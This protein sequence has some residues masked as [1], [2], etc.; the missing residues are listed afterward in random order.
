MDNFLTAEWVERYRLHWNEQSELLQGLKGFSALI[1]YGWED[2]S[3]PSAFLLVEDGRAIAAGWGE[4]PGKPVFVMKA[5]A[6]NWRRLRE[7]T[8]SGRAALLTKK[9]KFQGSMITAMKYMGPFEKSI[10]LLSAV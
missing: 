4:A 1:E 6:E 5:S 9:L 8:L 10:A 7:G 2:G 3:K